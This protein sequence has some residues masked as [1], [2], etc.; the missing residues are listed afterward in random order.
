MDHRR[1]C[2]GHGHRY[3]R[4]EP[5]SLWVTIFP[6]QGGAKVAS[7][8][9]DAHCW[10]DSEAEA[11]KLIKALAINYGLRGEFVATWR[12]CYGQETNYMTPFTACAPPAPPTVVEFS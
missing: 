4:P 5:Y 11:Q 2:K 10:A 1:H 9:T 8:T 3:C 7:G 6:A 12:H